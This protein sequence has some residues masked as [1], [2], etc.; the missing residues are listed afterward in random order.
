Y[1]PGN[2]ARLTQSFR[3]CATMPGAKMRGRRA[4]SAVRPRD[5]QPTLGD[6]SFRADAVRQR[7]AARARRGATER[8]HA[9]PA[10]DSPL[11][12]CDCLGHD[13]ASPD[14]RPRSLLGEVCGRDSHLGVLLADE[15]RKTSSTTTECRFQHCPLNK[16][17]LGAKAD[18]FCST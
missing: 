13:G 10:P 7:L 3:K 1:C 15:D 4:A 5:N 16:L 6:R 2:G 18:W 17:L 11:I 12:W 8:A 14:L 9:G